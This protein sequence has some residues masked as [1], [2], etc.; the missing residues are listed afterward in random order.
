MAETINLKPREPEQQRDTVQIDGTA[1]TITRL[2][3][4]LDAAKAGNRIRPWLSQAE[5]ARKDEERIARIRRENGIPAPEDWM[6]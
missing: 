2:P 5:Q 4:A 1:W 3:S 6:W